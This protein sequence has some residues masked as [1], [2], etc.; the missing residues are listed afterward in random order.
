MATGFSSSNTSVCTKRALII[1]NNK[2]RKNSPLRYC[3]NDAED[4][5]DK[6]RRIGFEITIETNLTYE[7]MDRVVETFKEEINPNDLVLFF[8]AGHGCQWNERN[9]LMPIDD[10][11]ITTDTDLEDRAINVQDT[12]EKIMSR[13]PSAAIFLLDCCRNSFIGESSNANGLS[14]MQAVADSFISFACDA[15]KV[16]VDESRNGRH[17]LF[18]S[19]LLRHIDQPYLTI[20]DIMCEVCDGA[21]KETNDDQCPFRVSSLQGKVYLNQQF[22]A[23][24]SILFI[25]VN[26]NTKWKQHGITVAGGN[27]HDYDSSQLFAM[28]G[29]YVD[30]DRQTIYIAGF[31]NNSI[32]EW[33]YGAQNGEV[34]V[35]GNGC[36]NRNDQLSFP[37]DVIVDKKN[38]SLII[39]DLGNR[40]VVEWSRRNGTNGETII[41]DIDCG[42]LTMDKNGD[43]YISD[44]EKNEVRRW[45]QREREGTVVAGGNGQ[46]D[47]LN[48]LHNPSYI[49]VDEDHS[50]YVSDTN[51]YRVMK[52]MKGAREGIVVAGGNGQGNSLAQLY[53]PEGVLVD[54]LGNVYVGDDANQRIMCWCEGS[55]EGSI[56]VGG[57]G[58]GEQPNQFRGPTDLSF[59]VEGNLYVVDQGNKRI[60]KFDIDSKFN[61]YDD[62]SKVASHINDDHM[63]MQCREKPLLFKEQN[64]LTNNLNIG[65]ANNTMVLVEQSS[66][67]KRQYNNRPTIYIID[68]EL[69]PIDW[70]LYM[71]RMEKYN[72]N[73]HLANVIRDLNRT[74]PLYILVSMPSSDV[75]HYYYLQTSS[76]AHANID[77]NVNDRISSINSID[78]FVSKLYEDLGQYY[79]DQA[80]IAET[81]LFDDQ[82][83]DPDAAKQLLTKSIKCFEI[84]A[85]YVEKTLKHYK[86]LANT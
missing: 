8:Y 5:A 41:S 48:Q 29:I 49:F 82:D 2:Y 62:R 73:S 34:V 43:L 77:L 46:G 7:E 3:I 71:V 86:N 32:I 70:D 31:A 4:L 54:H 14:P 68:L 24:Q 53:H 40:R 39:C 9:F 25:H 37:T 64:Q 85:L 6:L 63:S 36:G 12:L 78:Q 44:C 1:G 65:E 60:Q 72:M 74:I 75:L 52:W 26:I 15:N 83:R 58:E 18:T 66:T 56:V 16:A 59:D 21:M 84:L 81:A 20:D 28:Q 57:K 19:H 10:D 22:T 69:P 55:C 33:K 27:E 42:G 23:G 61:L 38:D 30:D 51:N 79:R 17:S 50:V 13:H 47:D 11:R 67:Y 35:G 45:K 76:N 80:E